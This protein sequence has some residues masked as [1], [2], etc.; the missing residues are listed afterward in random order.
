MIPG[1]LY[2]L[3]FPSVGRVDRSETKMKAS[4]SNLVSYLN[5]FSVAEIY[6][7]IIDAF[8]AKV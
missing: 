5:S 6:I 4:A 1:I 3:S 8:C 7:Y 2:D